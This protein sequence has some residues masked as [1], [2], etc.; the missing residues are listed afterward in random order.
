MV[1]Y[2]QADECVAH[3]EPKINMAARSVTGTNRVFV[4]F[5]RSS[6]LT[7]EVRRQPLEAGHRR[8]P[9]RETASGQNTARRSGCCLHRFVM[10]KLADTLVLETPIS[11]SFTQSQPM[12][13]NKPN[14]H[15]TQRPAFDKPMATL[16]KTTAR[17]PNS[18]FRRDDTSNAAELKSHKQTLTHNEKGQAP[19]TCGTNQPT[20][21]RTNLR[22]S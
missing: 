4:M 14:A 20:I 5:I 18:H 11:H 10:R 1:L 21:S 6:S 15:T 7:S 13:E 2:S 22:R 19:R 17:N 9:D 3:P 16:S 8:S 12:R